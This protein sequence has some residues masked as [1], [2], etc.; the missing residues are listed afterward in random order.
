MLR[1]LHLGKTVSGTHWTGDWVGLRVNLDVGEKKVLPL[2]GFEP[3]TSTL[4]RQSYSDSI[5]RGCSPYKAF[6][7]T[8]GDSEW[9]RT[10]RDVQISARDS[11]RGKLRDATSAVEATL[12]Q[13][14]ENGV[15]AKVKL[16]VKAS[17]FA[18]H[19]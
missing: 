1:P 7:W 13:V 9:V 18:L 15:S 16:H 5:N 3:R 8:T 14:H 10:M 11:V 19:S 6:R 12:R 2:P 4:Y 17:R